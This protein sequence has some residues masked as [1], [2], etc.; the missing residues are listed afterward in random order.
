MI[1][2]KG[3]N[4]KLYH[5]AL[6]PDV[7][8][9]TQIEL[10]PSEEKRLLKLTNA[11]FLRYV[12]DFDQLD[13]GSFWYVIKDSDEILENYKSKLRNQI[14]RG[15]KSCRVEKVDK[16][17]IARDGYEVYC[18]AIES[19]RT[20]KKLEDKE[21]FESSI[22]ESTGDFWAVYNLEQKLIAYSQNRIE[23]D[24]V[25]YM[26]IKF[27]PDY[28]KA[29]PSYALFFTMNQYYLNAQ[30]FKYVNDGARSISHMTNIQGFLIEKFHFRK[31][32]C[33]LHIVYRWDVGLIVK[34]LYP[35][36][37]LFGY[38]NSSVF[39][40]LKSLMKQEE[41]RRSYERKS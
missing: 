17:V 13:T 7:P 23:D 41:I 4:W 27:H 40:R 34:V 19:Y 38:F 29:Y 15:L 28:L 39:N 35:M 31:S 2:F 18:A 12:T 6:I 36:R 21:T 26:T 10:T 30:S 24:S 11:Y 25:N 14:R 1:T 16:V 20:K 3:I 22:L 5:G 8:P 33:R 32:Y 37:S 9:H